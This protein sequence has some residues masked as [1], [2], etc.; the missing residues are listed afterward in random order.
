MIYFS[1]NHKVMFILACKINYHHNFYVQSGIRH[2]YSHGGIPDILQVTEHQ[3]VKRKL[4][5]LWITLMVVSWTLATNCARFY[6]VA[7]CGDH[8]PPPDWQFGSTLNLEHVYNGFII[9]SLLEDHSLRQESLSVPHGGLDKDR[10]KVAMQA[11]NIQM[12]LYSQPELRH[13]CKKC[14]RFL[15]D[16]SL[17]WIFWKCPLMLITIV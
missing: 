1:L 15:N 4:I 13:Y 9:L 6:N 16:G 10:Y 14:T 8:R 17:V 12:Q 2:Y 5:N 11:R 7:F 3:F